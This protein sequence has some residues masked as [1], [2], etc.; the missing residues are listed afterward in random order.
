AKTFFTKDIP[1]K[2][3]AAQR[4]IRECID[5]WFME[6]SNLDETQTQPF[7]TLEVDHAFK[8]V[9]TGKSADDQLITSEL[10]N[11]SF[12]PLR[13]FWL[14][15]LH[16]CYQL[17]YFPTSLKI[18]L[19][20]LLPKPG[21]G[22][23]SLP[24]S[25]RP[26][27]ILPIIGKIL[28]FLILQRLIWWEQSSKIYNGYQFGFEQGKSHTGAVG[29]IVNHVEAAFKR[30]EVALLI[31]LDVEQAF[32]SAWHPAIFKTLVD[33]NCPE[34]L[35]LLLKS[36]LSDR[37]SELFFH[38][39]RHKVPLSASTV[40]GARLSPNLWKAVNHNIYLCILNWF[41]DNFWEQ[42]GVTIVFA[43]DNSILLIG[44]TERVLSLA[45][46][47]L[48]TH[49]VHSLAPLKIFFGLSKDKLELMGF[50]RRKYDKQE[51]K[52][53][54]DT[55]IEDYSGT[56][57]VLEVKRSTKLLGVILDSRLDWSLA[58]SDAARK[59][60]STLFELK[61]IVK[62]TWGLSS[63]VLKQLYQKV[64]VPTMLSNVA[65]WGPSF[66]S[67]QKNRR[68]LE[69]VD[70]L[71]CRM[72]TKAWASASTAVT[73]AIAGVI[74]I[75]LYSKRQ[76][77]IANLLKEKGFDPQSL[78][79]FEKSVSTSDLCYPPER[80]RFEFQLA[81]SKQCPDHSVIRSSGYEIYTDGSIQDGLGGGAV[82]VFHNSV[83]QKTILFRFPSHVDILQ[84]ECSM[85]CAATQTAS[86]LPD[87][88]NG[89][90]ESIRIYT[91]SYSTLS[92]MNSFK[93]K[94]SILPLLSTLRGVQKP[95]Q[96]VWVPSHCGFAG[97][98][99]ADALA[100]EA[101]LNA[102]LFDGIVLRTKRHT[103]RILRDQMLTEW[104]KSWLKSLKSL[105]PTSQYFQ[106]LFPTGIDDFRELW[107]I[108]KWTSQLA[109][110][111]TGHNFLDYF[112]DK[113]QKQLTLCK[114]CSKGAE[115][116]MHFLFAC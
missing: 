40:Q 91:D 46:A 30:D 34:D 23:Y 42:R 26:I 116:T 106:Q 25:Y 36:F 2:D 15:F 101:G 69:K 71:I 52:W 31:R 95:L 72:I 53:F 29:S 68:P 1:A 113:Q 27:A 59:G 75:T 103:L 99:R 13:T 90:S 57:V 18:D 49:L 94:P 17:A 112:L 87:A 79:L 82:V 89:N 4:K 78:H 35:V 45:A 92:G 83:E 111:Y 93:P 108:K 5:T 58:I 77:Q 74:P 11:L 20:I 28:E 41:T 84:I 100:K 47:D 19:S 43:D 66:L 24:R 8:S 9:P 12:G 88:P 96:F 44:S 3:T 22:D 16:S 65:L 6:H 115:D 55:V 81:G 63:C 110:V 61:A 80:K 54:C 7:S 73:Q 109:Q 51:D 21:K 107:K 37:V 67:A 32:P 86:E 104:S 56:E 64:V 50:S 14:K 48:V 85:L 70:R 97:N 39:E 76:K 114:Y 105:T 10:V 38:G 62:T 33:G 102:P 98:E 60:L